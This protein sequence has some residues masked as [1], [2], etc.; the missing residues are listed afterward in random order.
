MCN[1]CS[2]AMAGAGGQAGLAPAT[3]GAS[4]LY[5]ALLN[6][7][8]ARQNAGEALGTAVV[9]TY[10][11][12]RQGDFPGRNSGFLPVQRYE[13][14]NADDRDAVRTALDEYEKR[15]GITF[16]EMP[17]DGQ[18]D[19]MVAV[20][21]D[22][23]SW[24]YYPS[25]AVQP[26]VINKIAVNAGIDYGEE[27][28][29]NLLHEIGHGMGLKHSFEGYP[30]LAPQYDNYDYT[31][32]SYTP[33]T[34]LVTRLAPLDID[35]LR[36]YY[37]RPV[38]YPFTIAAAADGVSLLL[39]D[40]PGSHRIA[41][42]DYR[43]AVL[44]RGGNDTVI[45]NDRADDLDGGPG[46]DRI[47]ANGGNDGL[48]G[49]RGADTMHG[50][51]GRDTLEGN[52]GPDTMRGDAGNDLLRGAAD[53]DRLYG[54]P[55][56]DTLNGGIGNDVIDGEPGNDVLRGEDGAD[57]LDGGPGRDRIDG[58]LG[59]DILSGGA[60]DDIVHGGI[61]SDH[62]AG[63]GGT[64]TLTG[65]GGN[66][67]IEA[68]AAGSFMR[69]DAGHDVIYGAGGGDT[70]EGGSGNDLIRTGGGHDSVEAGSRDDTVYGG[71]GNDTVKGGTGDDLLDGQSGADRMIGEAGNDTLRGA[72]QPDEL[73]GNSGDD[74]LFG[75]AGADTLMGQHGND[76]LDGGGGPDLLVGAIGNDVLRSGSGRGGDTL[77]GGPGD[78]RLHANTDPG[79]RD[80][81]VFRSGYGSDEVFGFDA[82]DRLDIAVNGVTPA[83]LAALAFQDGPDVLFDFGAGDRLLLHVVDLAIITDDI[84]I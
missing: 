1:F 13:P 47:L 33:G 69:G 51:D 79:S 78:D 67:T 46:R 65:E 26:V 25:P 77:D 11:F 4:P 61:G 34:G 58:G 66:D 63:N 48:V 52:A 59:P 62:L 75:D 8:G 74:R 3:A 36:H 9:V 29:Q 12:A 16:V 76:T 70:V 73:F 56:N 39:T 38:D 22:G 15:A 57:T 32:M 10:S 53:D 6:E 23:Y 82:A 54:G 80:T 44:A 30:V 7:S 5:E 60:G 20:G 40:R 24:A 42:S 37:G 31:V 28:Y 50:G 71:L 49:G 43:L 19:F 35:A 41:L 64:D 72:E 68:S 21:A 14:M 84:F 83:G 18:L 81:I 27:A 17:D 55:D 45:G 2:A